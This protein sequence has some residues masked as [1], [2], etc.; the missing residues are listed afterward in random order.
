MHTHTYI[1]IG[2]KQT[3]R[4]SNVW[5]KHVLKGTERSLSAFGTVHPASE[6]DAQNLFRKTKECKSH[7]SQ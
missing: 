4:F 2:G 6:P 1:H 3:C 7:F 5:N